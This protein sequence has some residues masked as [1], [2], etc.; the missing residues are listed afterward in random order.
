MNTR[1]TRLN[2]RCIT[3]ADCSIGKLTKGAS[4]GALCIA[5][6]HF[7]LVPQNGHHFPHSEVKRGKTTALALQNFKVTSHSLRIHSTNLWHGWVHQFYEGVEM[8]AVL[9]SRITQLL[10]LTPPHLNFA[11]VVADLHRTLTSP[12]LAAPALTWDCD[13][14]ALVDFDAGRMVISFS[15]NLPGQHAACLTIAAGSSLSPDAAVLSDADQ[16]VLCQAVSDRL[17]RQYPSDAKQSQSI[18]QPLTPDV[19]DQVVEALFYKTPASPATHHLAESDVSAVPIAASGPGDV[20]RLMSMLSHEL[21]TRTPSLIS[22]AIASATQRTRS[23]VEKSKPQ[24]DCAAALLAKAQKANT[25][26][27]SDRP[28]KLFWSKSANT[29]TTSSVAA[30]PHYAAELDPQR[31]ASAELKAVRDALY[32]ADQAGIARSGREVGG[33]I[34]AQTTRAFQVLASFPASIANSVT[35]LRRSNADANRIRH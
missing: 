23:A 21:V 11:Q 14:I 33:R 8:S 26:V 35:D 27:R 32:A 28:G 2:I 7:H 1:R 10:Y 18:A 3:P 12:A 29:R 22:R 9:T 24:P 25:T 30:M 5:A 6:C 15:D 31:V 17:Q 16:I 20:D 34:A 4:R 19:I 13:D